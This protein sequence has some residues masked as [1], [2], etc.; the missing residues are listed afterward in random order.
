MQLLR[1][2]DVLVFEIHEELSKVLDD[3]VGLLRGV[4]SCELT[5]SPSL[6]TRCL[7]LELDV[8][9]DVINYDIFV[10]KFWHSVSSLLL[11]LNLTES[12]SDFSSHHVCLDDL[13]T[14]VLG[15]RGNSPL[16][17]DSLVNFLCSL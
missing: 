7:R 1:I 2:D 6:V 12:F 3:H 16:A 14:P 13:I 10:V 9:S 5:E 15:I 8:L 11:L 4:R 17:F